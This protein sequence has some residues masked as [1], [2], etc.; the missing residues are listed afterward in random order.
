VDAAL[1]LKFQSPHSPPDVMSKVLAYSSN[2]IANQVLITFGIKTHR[3]PGTLDNAVEA[4][5]E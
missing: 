2:C 4:L 1:L 5:S 3:P